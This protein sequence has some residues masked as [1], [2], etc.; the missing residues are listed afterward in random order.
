MWDERECGDKHNS[1]ADIISSWVIVGVIVVGV[2][3]GAGF[4]LF[5]MDTSAPNMAGRVALE[6]SEIPTVLSAIAPADDSR[7]R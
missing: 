7:Q 3:V 1:A 4:Q 6:S 2:A 5:M